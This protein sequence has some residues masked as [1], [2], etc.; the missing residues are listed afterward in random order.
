M[1]EKISHEAASWS[2]DPFPVDAIHV[3]HPS[4]DQPNDSPKLHPVSDWTVWPVLH[5][6]PKHDQ[7]VLAL[8][9]TI[10]SAP[11]TLLTA[12][13]TTHHPHTCSSWQTAVLQSCHLAPLSFSPDTPGGI[14]TVDQQLYLRKMISCLDR[15]HVSSSPKARSSMSFSSS[16]GSGSRS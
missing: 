12:G 5:V 13:S 4:T 6:K 9:P 16:S 3:L 10:R 1:A 7:C 14:Y 8:A 15:A 2:N 11:F